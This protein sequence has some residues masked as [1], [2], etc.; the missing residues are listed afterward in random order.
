MQYQE[1]IMKIVIIED[2]EI[3][4]LELSKLLKKQGYG[5][6]LLTNFK[7]LTE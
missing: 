4:R 1:V 2:E 5:T 6:L 7:N 3:T